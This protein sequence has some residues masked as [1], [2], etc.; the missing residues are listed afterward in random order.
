VTHLLF[1]SATDIDA[2]ENK[3]YE[4]PPELSH[5]VEIAQM[6]MNEYDMTHKSKLN[7]VLFK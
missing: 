2:A 7:I 3:K 6:V 5:F 1:T 4:E